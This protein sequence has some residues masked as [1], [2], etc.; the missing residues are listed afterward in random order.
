MRMQGRWSPDR[1]GTW[2]IESEDET[3][4]KRANDEIKNIYNCATVHI[5]GGASLA[6][7]KSKSGGRSGSIGSGFFYKSASSL[8]KDSAAK[9]AAVASVPVLASTAK[10]KSHLDVDDLFENETA[11]AEEMQQSPSGGVLPVLL[12]AGLMLLGKRRRE[13]GA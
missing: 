12:A 10:K 13:T 3:I 2:D 11:E 8:S 9:A 6:E 4:F 1:G 5:V 7:A